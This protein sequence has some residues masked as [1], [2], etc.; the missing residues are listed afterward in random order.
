MSFVYS[1]NH[2]IRICPHCQ[3]QN[4]IPAAYLASTGKCGRC[5]QLLAPLAEPLDV[6]SAEFDAL[7]RDARVPVMVDF[8]AEWCGPCKMTAPEYAKAAKALA[9]KAVLLKVNTETE[10]QLAARFQVR[11][12]PN[13]KIFVGGDRKLDQAGALSA[14][15]IQQLVSR[16]I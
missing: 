1:E 12:I 3:T 9:G 10:P 6:S 11:S 15:Q 14:V 4:R 7:V 5:K 13:F 16:F 2:M 8:W